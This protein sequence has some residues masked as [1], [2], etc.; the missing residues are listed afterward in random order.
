MI[1][2]EAVMSAASPQDPETRRLVSVDALRG[3]DMFWIVG[4]AGV[5]TALKSIGDNAVLN[6]FA[7]QLEHK[8][9][10]G[11]AFEDLIF[12]LFV[13]IVGISLVFSLGRLLANEGRWAAYKRLFRRFFLL[14]LLGI[15]YYGGLSNHWPDI[16]LVGVLQRLALCY[17]FAGLL[18]C[19]L[20]ARGLI[21][22]C[23]ALLVGYWAW[24]TFIPVPDLGVTTFAK[25]KNWACYFDKMYLPG[26]R[27]YGD[28]TWDP[29][30]ILSTLPAVASCLL[31]VLAGLL[32]SN[33]SVSD[34]R[35]L[36][37]LIGGGVLGVLLGFLWGY[38]FPVIKKIWTSSYVLVAGGYSGILLGLFYLVVDIWKLR[39]W[40]RP[41]VWIGSNA[42][43]VYLAVNIWD[44]EKVARRF[45][46]GD[47]QDA[48]G[49]Y[50]DL[51]LTAITLGL[52]LALARFLY[53]KRIFIRV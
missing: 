20:R 13:F 1:A 12:P 18:F 10:D 2:A 41:F 7:T 22:V 45:A 32:I 37:Y 35:K 40:A 33:P 34:R 28:G 6:F 9:W 49:R 46:G 48:L 8:D 50:G 31:G 15:F 52:V 29:E 19:H 38:Q 51:V 44:V 43:T 4:A 14:Y 36:L 27:I 24:L 16:R 23:A 42:L 25:G 26:K 21:A 53:R 17:L 47:V 30:G 39:L 5:V 11:F 3:F